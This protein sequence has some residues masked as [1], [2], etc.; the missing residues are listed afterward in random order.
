[1][2]AKEQ[3]IFKLINNYRQQYD[4]PAL[5]PSVNLAYVARTHAIDIIENNPDVNG[6]N[7]HSWSDK[8]KWKPVRYT[9]DHAQAALMWNKPS[10]ISNYNF[11]GYEISYGYAQNARKTATVNP[12]DAVNSWKNSKG[13]NDVIIQQG[14][15]QNTQMTSMGVGV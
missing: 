8:G 13:H 15:F 3:E 2:D 10:E 11:N 12:V 5:Q 4:L 14:A 7:M 9:P 6:G 1:M